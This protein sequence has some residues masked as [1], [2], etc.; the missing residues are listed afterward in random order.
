[1][2]MKKK[3]MKKKGMARGGAKMKMRGGGMGMTKKK[4][5]MARGGAMRARK[6]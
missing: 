6:K 5:G 4:K 2:A 1:M 3:P